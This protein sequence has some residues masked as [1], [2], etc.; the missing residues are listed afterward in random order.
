MTHMHSA[1]LATHP[2]VEHLLL[3]ISIVLVTARQHYG[4]GRVRIPA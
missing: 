2:G 3:P 1:L 4:V